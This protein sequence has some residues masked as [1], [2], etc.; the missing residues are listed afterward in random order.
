MACL[1]DFNSIENLLMHMAWLQLSIE[2]SIFLTKRM[3]CCEMHMF[4]LPSYLLKSCLLLNNGVWETLT[5]QSV[6]RLK[7]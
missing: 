7:K 3:E 4:G 2:L 1:E 5:F 6:W